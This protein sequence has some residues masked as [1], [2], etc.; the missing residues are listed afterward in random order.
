MEPHEL[1]A[2]LRFSFLLADDYHFVSSWV[3]PE[4]ILP[5]S[6]LRFITKGSADFFLDGASTAVG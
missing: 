4:S 3:Y 6:L 5:Y 2:G 1:Y